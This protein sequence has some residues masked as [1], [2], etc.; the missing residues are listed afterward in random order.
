MLVAG[1]TQFAGLSRSQ[2]RIKPYTSGIS[3]R[4]AYFEITR[5]CFVM[6][7]L[8]ASVSLSVHP[9]GATRLPTTLIN[10]YFIVHEPRTQ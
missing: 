5:R 7:R 6:K 1:T 3:L 2:P 10:I 4:L 8:L 9:R